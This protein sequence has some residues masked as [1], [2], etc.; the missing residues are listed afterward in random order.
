MKIF[1]PFKQR[2]V[3]WIWGLTSN[4]ADAARLVSESLAEALS[5]G[6]RLRMR[7]PAAVLCSTR[8]RRCNQLEHYFHSG[9]KPT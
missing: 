6:P 9:A 3:A 2:C 7:L 1:Q 5:F 8:V 4:G